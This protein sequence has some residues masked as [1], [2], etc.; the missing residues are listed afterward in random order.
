VDACVGLV[1]S[2]QI[3]VHV[4]AKHLPGGGILDETIDRG[5]RVRRH[6][7][8]PPAD[9]I[10]VV[11]LMRRLDKNDPKAPLC[12]DLCSSSDGSRGGH[13]GLS[14]VTPFRL[15]TAKLALA[16]QETLDYQTIAGGAIRSRVIDLTLAQP[17]SC[18][19]M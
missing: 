4:G 11:V 7:R 10:A 13:D 1:D 5:E 17:A 12:A 3:D 8:A 15:I 6:G 14:L 16:I 9:D 18:I 2:G 19:T